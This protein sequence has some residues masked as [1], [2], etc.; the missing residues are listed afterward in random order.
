MLRCKY[1]ELPLRENRSLVTEKDLEKPRT[2]KELTSY[3]EELFAAIQEN[4]SERQSARTRKGLYKPLME[5]LWPISWY[6]TRKY[7]SS[8]FRLKLELGNQGFDAVVFDEAGAPVERIEVT[9][10]IDGH[11]H[12]EAMRLLNERGYGL[13]EIYDDP[14]D[15][16]KD[17]IE[18][19]LAG[20]QKKAVRE[21]RFE[22]HSTLALV[23]D[24]SLYYHP[25]DPTH[26][27]EINRLVN[28]LSQL[29]YHVDNVVLLLAH[30]REIINVGGVG[31]IANDF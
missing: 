12:F 15:K 13:V 21:Y 29:K 2:A 4:Q 7:A 26:C 5:E 11:K 27:N 24:V 3:L 9:W 17:V 10:P 22:G 6:F 18:L 1:D 28:K 8:A 25:D 23:V 14:L 19:T 16:L 20:A 31:R 30:S